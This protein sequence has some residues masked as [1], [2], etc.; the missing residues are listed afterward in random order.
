[1]RP[2]QR[3]RSIRQH[4]S[5]RPRHCRQCGR[6]I[7]Q[8]RRDR[9]W[10]DG[11]NGEPNCVTRRNARYLWWNS[12]VYVREKVYAR[13]H[14]ICAACGRDC[15]KPAGGGYQG[16]QFVF[17]RGDWDADHVVP[18]ADGGR[19]SMVNLQTLCHEP[20]HA[21]K[22]AKENAK[23]RDAKWLLKWAKREV[24]RRRSQR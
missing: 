1:M 23:R 17:P 22:T 2:R 18:L 9:R 19:H 10:H 4:V 8:G 5:D 14:G 24:R 13:D 11:R 12:T 16:R 15:S 3:W 21:R 6:P 7:T 20:C